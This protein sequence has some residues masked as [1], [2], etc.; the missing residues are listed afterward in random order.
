MTAGITAA[1]FD[2]WHGDPCAFIESV[3]IDP[4]VGTPYVLNRAQRRF[5]ARAF[6]LTADG[7][8]RYPELLFS[9]PKK[10][11]KTALAAMLVIYVVVI[12]AGPFGEGIICSNSLEQAQARVFQAVTRMVIASPLLKDDAI[13]TTT[14]ITFRS[15]GGTIIALASDFTTAAGAN[16][17]CVCF[18]ELWG[19]VSERDTRLFD[20]MVP[21]PARRISCRLTVSY[22]GYEGESSP[23]E[24]L[25]KRGLQGTQ[26]EPDMY[27]APGMLT[28]WTNDFIAPWQ[29]ETWREEMRAALRPNAYLRLIE[30]RWVTSESSFVDMDWWDACVDPTVHPL[31]IDK[32]RRIYVG[33]DAS[34]KRDSTAIVA[35][36]WNTEEKKVD[37]VWHRVFQPSPNDPLDFEKTIEA[38][39]LDLR[40]RFYV[41]EVRYDPYQM[42]AVAQRL[43]AEGLPMIEFPQTSGNLTAMGN[44]LY[45]IIKGRTLIAYPDAGMRLA[46][47]RAVAVENA[48]GWRIA[49]EKQSHKI[50]IVISLA[51]AAL[52]AVM[53]GQ[54]PDLENWRKIG[55]SALMPRPPAPEAPVV[56]AILMAANHA[57]VAALTIAGEPVAVV[58]LSER[59]GFTLNNGRMVMLAKGQLIEIPQR[60]LDN[61]NWLL[62]DGLRVCRVEMVEI[63]DAAWGRGHP[64]I[65]L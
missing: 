48:R 40:D 64:A 56:P 4:E 34:T 50:D 61:E 29:T 27:V 60:L 47:Q 9:C 46:I 53:E 17:S 25:Y 52:G 10:S 51:M 20:E 2:R 62:R 36:G 63:R 28:F 42:A 39:M 38:S 23:L 14:K 49:T 16:P 7:R 13:I 1:D 55:E 21:S 35:C 22:A 43:T 5:I 54:Q 65:A 57:G 24:T 37:L 11:G 59:V 30:N 19:Y 3:L 41:G 44:N 45:E 15:T 58:A 32:N 33:I 26:V 12:L 18:D 6:S 8:L 31:L